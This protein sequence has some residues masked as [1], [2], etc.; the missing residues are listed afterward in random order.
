MLRAFISQMRLFQ[1]AEDGSMMIFGLFI[2]VAMLIAG[3]MGVDFMRAERER[4]EL[5]YALDRALLASASLSQRLE[6]EDVVRDYLIK[7]N[8]NA[9]DLEITATTSINSRRVSASAHNTV[10]SIFVNMLGITELDVHASGAAEERVQNVEVSLVLD[11]S[12]SMGNNDKMDNMKDAAVDFVDSMLAA[13]DRDLVSITLIPYNMQVNAGPG[14]LSQ[15]SVT[16]EHTHSHCVDF[17]RD[18]FLT[19]R[20][21]PGTRYQRTGHFDPFVTSIDHPNS[22]SD[23]DDRRLFMC[24][25]EE[26]SEIVL[27]SQ[28]VNELKNRINAM[29][30]GGNTSIDIGVRWGAMFLDPSARSIITGASG[31]Q[32]VEGVFHDRPAPFEDEETIKI[33]VVMTDG[34]NTTQYTLDNE[35]DSGL[36]NVW[37]DPDST[38]L[39]IYDSRERDYFITNTYGNNYYDRNGNGR[40]MYGDLDDDGRMET[41]RGEYRKWSNEPYNP[42]R[43]IRMTWPEV[44]AMMGT[45]YNAYYNNYAMRSW[46]SDYYRWRDQVID[47]I[48]GSTKDDR[49]R[50]ACTAAKR[51][52]IIIFAIGFEVTTQSAQVMQDCASSDAH[53]FRVEGIEIADAFNA[54]AQTVQRL[55]LTQ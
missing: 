14:I 51:N 37:R 25:T 46:S 50:N 54:I 13:R 28:D 27:V 26:F 7:A 4:A 55:K 2:F 52:D 41:N 53:F 17:K 12:G 38:I 48:G 21:E 16:S 35:Y 33:I 43:A 22:S 3:G 45:R 10:R 34:I 5:Q 8:I 42:D 15:M 18:Q 31:D 9:E 1:R 39:S 47:R 36:S 6:P 11:V 24:P 23:D 20:F 32:A 29:V 44:W 19:S 30:A 40:A 49:L